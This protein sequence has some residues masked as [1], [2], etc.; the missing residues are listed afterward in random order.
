MEPLKYPKLLV[1]ELITKLANRVF[2]L[3]VNIMEPLKYPKLLQIAID[4]MKPISAL[5]HPPIQLQT[6][7]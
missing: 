2:S 3:S 6:P 1:L 7:Q 5:N 4:Y